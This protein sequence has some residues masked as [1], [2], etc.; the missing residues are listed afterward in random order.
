MNIENDSHTEDLAKIDARIKQ[1][2]DD[3]DDVQLRDAY[4]SK[5]ELY[6]GQSQYEQAIENYQLALSKTAGAQKK[7]EYQLA[8]L[9]I[10]F[11]REDFAKFG[12]QLELC[13]RLNEEG[14]DWEKKNKLL[15]YEGLWMIKKRDLEAA[16]TTL[17]S[18]VNTF[19]APEIIPF[20]KLVFYG[21]VLGMVTLQR[22]D[23]KSKVID[24]SDIVAVLREEKTLYDYLF[25]LY[26]RR[27]SDFF[28]NLSKLTSLHHRGQDRGRQIPGRAQKVLPQTREK[29]RLRPIPGKLQDSAPGENG[30]R[31]R[32]LRRLHR[33]GALPAHR[34]QEA[35]LPDRPGQRDR[36]VVEGRPPRGHVQ[37]DPEEGRQPGGEDV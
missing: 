37:R 32:R 18:C 34:Q 13:K 9:H 16:A 23:L 5:A 2:Q 28:K 14:G 25:S 12:D 1:A 3:G 29:S 21:V 6:E 15:V 30:S 4:I 36:G 27:Y 35:Q 17:L 20:E 19:N 8:V 11:L 22:K 10:Y 7:L 31:F 26:E 33:Q 24:N